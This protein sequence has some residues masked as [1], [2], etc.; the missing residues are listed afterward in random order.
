MFGISIANFSSELPPPQKT[1]KKA[2][3]TYLELKTKV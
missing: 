1:R 3:N 2:E